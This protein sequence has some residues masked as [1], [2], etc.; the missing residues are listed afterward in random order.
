MIRQFAS[1]FLLSGLVAVSLAGVA[2]CSGSSS[3]PNTAVGTGVVLGTSGT[4][5]LTPGGSVI[6]AAN[7]LNDPKSLGVKWSLSGAGTLSAQ[8][9]TQVTYTAPA[10]LVGTTTA[11][12]TATS[13][14]DTTMVANVTATTSGLPQLQ[15]QTSLPA[16]QHVGYGTSI[17]VTGGVAPYLW[18]ISSGQI[19]PG[20][21]LNGSTGAVLGI[22][23][24]PSAIGVWNFTVQVTDHNS[25]V[26][27]GNYQ[28]QVNPQA[29]CLL[30]GTFA[31]KLHGFSKT[32]A[33]ATRAGM[34]TVDANGRVRGIQDV[35]SDVTTKIGE[36]VT[37]GLCQNQIGNHGV[38]TF[39]SAS[40]TLV[41]DWAMLASLNDG[42]MQETDGSG[43]A[44][45]ASFVRVDPSAV[46]TT[47][48]A[49]LTGD[50]A[51]GVVGV[52]A[53]FERRGVVGRLTINADGSVQGGVADSNGSAPVTDGSV[54]GTFTADPTYPSR[55][56]A[57]LNVNGTS[58]GFVYYVVSG[59]DGRKIYL[60]ESDSGAATP[61]L[62][63]DLSPQTTS[64]F[65]NYSFAPPFALGVTYT[66]AIMELISSTGAHYPSSTTTLAQ[67]VTEPNHAL[68][69]VVD[70]ATGGSNVL[71]VLNSATSTLTP[72]S[73]RV[74]FTLGTGTGKRTFV[75]YLTAT[76]AGYVIET[77]ANAGNGFGYLEAQ[78]DFP[79]TAFPGGT[80]LGTTILPPTISP[81]T[82]LPAVTVQG[83]VFGGGF[84]GQYALDT[85]AG[86]GI[87]LL[88]RD[89]FGGS[90]LVFYI[91]NN[92]KIVL[93]GNGANALNPQMGYLYY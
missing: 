41:F 60:M 68:L 83:G 84:S 61:I 22:S 53:Q 5:S 71:D 37:D 78:A 6:I 88:S 28:I 52:D 56:S 79:Y 45:T 76:S 44:G 66:P 1:R 30:Q 14:A 70:T 50:Y 18:Q 19:P 86:R 77:T 16:N 81:I 40:G 57:S 7:V 38:I 17:A 65:S 72:A 12:I 85:T 55:G 10:S 49:N 47:R 33:S 82:L 69:A 8:S 4:T 15:A 21:A 93:M 67:I 75:G 63:G 48:T 23:G 42:F 80:Y 59:R 24:T 13:I 34:F 58:L 26:A 46:T 35:K 91:V 27:Q 25:R 54:T 36:S 62:A 9:T 64:P 3:A 43:I 39:I 20:L 92:S 31:Y 2:G 73:G 29:S 11:T 87:A 32:G 51:F 89:V 90:G 74:A